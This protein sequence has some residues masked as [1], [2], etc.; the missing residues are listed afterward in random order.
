MD[1][2]T[3]TR[4]TMESGG[5]KIKNKTKI[6]KINTAYKIIKESLLRL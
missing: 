1:T 3:V 4:G 2:V 6:F 5:L